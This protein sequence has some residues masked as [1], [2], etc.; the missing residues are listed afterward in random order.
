MGLDFAAG[1]LDVTASGDYDGQNAT[2]V[3]RV[4]LGGV[5]LNKTPKPAP[6]S[7]P[8]PARPVL[9]NYALT[10][11]AAGKYA[12]LPN[13][14]AQ[15]TLGTLTVDGKL[16]AVNKTAGRDIS[17]TT[18]PNGVVPSA[19]LTLAAD[20]KQVNDVL[21]ALSDEPVQL[22]A[23]NGQQAGGL[24]SGKLA[25]AIQVQPFENEQFKV[26]TRDLKLT[27]L[28]AAGE[29][30]AAAL[31][32]ETLAIDLQARPQ[33]DFSAVAVDRLTV[34]GKLANISVEKAQIVLT[35]GKGDAARPATVPE[36]VQTAAVK[37]TVPN[38]GQVQ[39]LLDALSPPAAPAGARRRAS[40]LP[41]ALAQAG[42]VDPNAVIS[43]PA[44]RGAVGARRQ[45]RSRRRVPPRR[46][47]PSRKRRRCGS[48]AAASW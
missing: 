42:P 31:N 14:Q 41:E 36:M 17:I 22:V 23:A 32:N 1:S 3:A 39:S 6:G 8:L 34:D 2:Y 33:A 40:P 20:L 10:I 5:S 38:M 12:A 28:T 45:R 9:A 7:K 13:D 19:D 25:G 21:A 26:T 11:D 44:N 24:R 16:F 30:G 35:I 29:G 47:Q 46:Q 48:R 27:E 15:I 4:A 18:G 37:V 43:R